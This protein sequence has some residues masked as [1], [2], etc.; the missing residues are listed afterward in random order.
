MASSVILEGSDGVSG[1]HYASVFK[2]K[3]PR[4]RLA[5]A[6]HFL[7]YLVYRKIMTLNR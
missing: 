2:T 5:S 3:Q 6:S 7:P 1:P 4:S